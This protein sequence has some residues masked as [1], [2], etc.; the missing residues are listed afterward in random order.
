VFGCGGGPVR[1]PFLLENLTSSLTGWV[2]RREVHVQTELKKAKTT[3]QQ[4]DMGVLHTKLIWCLEWLQKLQGTYS[5]GSIIALEKWKAP[6]DK[7]RK[8]A[9]ILTIGADGG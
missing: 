9:A 7:Q 6:A 4:V 8:R 1:F 3:A 2:I 5:P